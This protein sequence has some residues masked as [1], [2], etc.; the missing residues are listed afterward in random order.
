M[1]E[2]VSLCL[3][4][5]AITLFRAAAPPPVVGCVEAPLACEWL[6][7]FR[8]ADTPPKRYN[9]RFKPYQR[10]AGVRE[11]R[12]AALTTAPAAPAA[13]AVPKPEYMGNDAAREKVE[14]WLRS[15]DAA[16]DKA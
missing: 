14:E 8:V 11:H 12:L 4:H 9:T 3:G 2:T 15:T 7:G 16:R 10:P 6:P 13:P 1:M 5:L